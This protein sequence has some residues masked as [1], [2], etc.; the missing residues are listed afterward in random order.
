MWIPRYVPSERVVGED[1]PEAGLDEVVEPLVERPGS[2]A[3][4]SREARSRG[5]TVSRACRV[6]VMRLSVGAA[7]EADAPRADASASARLDRPVGRRDRR[8][9]SRP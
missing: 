9:G 8:L 4:G 7:G 3:G 1:P 6:L 2:R 5:S